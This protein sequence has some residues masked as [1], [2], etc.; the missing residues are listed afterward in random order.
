M[1]IGVYL[2]LTILLIPGTILT[3]SWSVLFGVRYGAFSTLIGVTLG[4]TAAFLIG[5]YFVRNWV[6]KKIE[7]S[8]KF[9]AIDAA[10]DQEGLKIVFLTRRSP[11]FPSVLLNYAFGVTNGSQDYIVGC[12]GMIPGTIL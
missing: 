12:A 6:A 11:V 1:F 2:L 8:S 7:S 10:V 4:A 5:R 3:L 9:K